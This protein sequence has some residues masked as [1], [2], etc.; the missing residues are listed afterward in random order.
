[1][2]SIA[3]GQVDDI[4]IDRAASRMNADDATALADEAVYRSLV[5]QG[6]AEAA[7][8]LGQVTVVDGPE[9]RVAVAERRG[10]SVFGAGQ[11]QTVAGKEAAL[12]DAPFIGC[13]LELGLTH[14]AGV[15]QFLSEIDGARPVLSAGVDS[16]LDD[17]YSEVFPCEPESGGDSRGAAADDDD[18]PQLLAHRRSLR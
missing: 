4:S 13:G 5:E 2:R 10:V 18:I 1:M 15:G 17:Q 9:N 6:H 11:R 3:L 14:D 7:S 16:G 12:D 8:V